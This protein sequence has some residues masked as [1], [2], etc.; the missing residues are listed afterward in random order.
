LEENAI[1]ENIIANVKEQLL[2]FWLMFMANLML[3]L[4]P[5]PKNDEPPS[6]LISCYLADFKLFMNK[7]I[8]NYVHKKWDNAPYIPTFYSFLHFLGSVIPLYT[9]FSVFRPSVWIRKNQ[10][11]LNWCPASC[12]CVIHYNII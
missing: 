8:M 2:N 1:L 4:Y 11:N 12:T 3:W 9:L 7:I 6:K 5:H 10:R